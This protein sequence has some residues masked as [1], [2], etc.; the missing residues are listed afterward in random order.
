MG[1]V[2]GVLLTVVVVLKV[3]VPVIHVCISVVMVH[4]LRTIRHALLLV[5]VSSVWVTIVLTVLFESLL[6]LLIAVLI[7]NALKGHLHHFWV[8]WISRLS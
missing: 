6:D 3:V 4:V 7:L 2:L 1:S 8:D 5:E